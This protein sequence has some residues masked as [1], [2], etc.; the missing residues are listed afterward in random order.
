MRILDPIVLAQKCMVKEVD[1]PGP[2]LSLSASPP[3]HLG[4]TG[5]RESTTQEENTRHQTSDTTFYKSDRNQTQDMRQETQDTRHKTPDSKH[6]IQ[7][8]RHKT[9]DLRLPVEFF[10]PPPK[11]MPDWCKWPKV[12]K[13]YTPV[14]TRNSQ[15]VKILNYFIA[16]N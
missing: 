8:A 15:E 12:Y 1:L 4:W 13:R 3:R 2:P 16:S 14:K 9:Q 7:D 5:G 10:V 6:K 11:C